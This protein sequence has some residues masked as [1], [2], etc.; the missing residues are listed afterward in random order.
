[1]NKSIKR[2]STSLLIT[3]TIFVTQLP[4][5]ADAETK[6]TVTT[7]ILNVRSSTS[8]TSSIVGQLKEGEV[9]SVL[10]T[11]GTWSQIDFNGSKRYVASSYLKT[12]TAISASSTVERFKT[13][14]KL[15]LRSTMSFSAP[16]INT[17]PE[18]HEVRL[19]SKHGDWYRVTY[20]RKTG[21][22]ASQY[23]KSQSGGDAINK[24]S[25]SIV[26][27]TIFTTNRKV[28]L[29]SST[30]YSSSIVRM[31]EQGKEVHLISTHGNWVRIKF[32]AKTGY[33]SINDVT[34]KDKIDS[35][36]SASTP[37]KY[38][39]N[40]NLNFR[41]SPTFSD[42][43][44]KVIPKGHE[45]YH[46]SNHG[47]WVKVRYGNR[48][49]YL[50]K[51]HLTPITSKPMEPLETTVS[52]SP[53]FKLLKSLVLRA[54]AS[55]TSTAI[56]TIETGKE[57]HVLAVKGDWYKVKFGTK[58]GY[59]PIADLKEVVEVEAPPSGSIITIGKYNVT[60]DLNLRSG[61]AETYTSLKVI[62][63]GKEV[64]LISQHGKWFK[65]KYG[66]SIGY[67]DSTYLKEAVEVP[68]FL[69]KAIVTAN[70]TLNIR[71]TPEVADNL[72]GKL[73]YNQIVPV[74]E[75]TNSS[76]AKIEFY[77]NDVLTNAYVSR[78][79][80]T[81]Y[82]GPDVPEAQPGE[83]NVVL[84]YTD[85]PY[86]LV[87]MLGKQAS[88]YGQTD[89]YRNAPGYVSKDYV[90]PI[91]GTRNGKIT[92]ST[93]NVRSEPNSTSHIYG[94]LPLNTTVTI[95]GQ[96]SDF[97]TISYTRKAGQGERVFDNTWRIA[98]NED[99]LKYIDP[100]SVQFNDVN[101]SSREAFQ[102][103]DL[104][105]SANVPATVLNNALQSKGILSGQGQ[106]FVNAARDFNINEVY[107]MSHAFLETGNG[108][109]T[110]ASGVWVD[111][112]GNLSTSSATNYKMVY[113][114]FG[115]GA[116]DSNPTASGAKH[117]FVQ[118]W[119]SPESAIY[120]GGKWISEKYINNS[121]NQ[122][123]LYKM[124]FNPDNPG[125][126][127]YAT[128]IGWAYKQTN[129]LYTTYQLLNSY[130]AHFDIPRFIY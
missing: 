103:L 76:W 89:A 100:R 51:E 88:V 64:H 71:S 119:F 54:A 18:G 57:V 92:A 48:F 21:Y 118:G 72:I 117:A 43:V 14:A 106:A 101:G 73:S 80:L 58:I 7:P 41:T 56:R 70:P 3:S 109:S 15:N 59:L 4:Y 95:T 61:P 91:D 13:T 63:K 104:S 24:T 128:D 55:S 19:V 16:V 45:V 108:T 25:T 50:T 121:R 87:Y 30:S 12:N 97:Y 40:V 52:G 94:V 26:T 90:V 11:S 114:M 125:I 78:Q 27:S 60:A 77:V 127:Q 23:L 32:G 8:T 29:H 37:E 1:M 123:T 110:L 31:I 47:A 99:I 82:E 28:N 74:L 111:Q 17:I 68:T 9:V 69:Y 120:G 65:V 79:Y 98:K 86:S 62:P 129:T 93:L 122:N 67:M 83:K 116:I 10:G 107:L 6:A 126:N 102:Y 53:K 66:A 75:N 2:L 112:N 85:Y 38:T 49:G 96:V 33:V 115:I 20:G 35:D 36:S 81:S 39:L 105:K 42:N 22:V 84:N 46:L 34:E 113:N 44:I 5:Q 124:R 130:T